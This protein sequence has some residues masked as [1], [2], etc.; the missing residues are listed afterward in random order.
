MA[1][2]NNS[3]L[4]E[5]SGKIGDK[6]FRQMY[7]KT[8]VSERPQNYKAAKTP[9]ARKARSSFGMAVKLAKKL[10]ADPELNEIWTA[11]KIDGVNSNQRILKHNLK[12]FDGGSLTP[13]NIITPEG[14]F[15][16]VESSSFQ[17]QIIHLSLN[18]PAEN[19]LT[20]PAE[21]FLLYYFEKENKSIV[22]NR[23]VITES[24]AGGIYEIDINPDK[25]LL[26]LLQKDP[27][28][29]LFIA[30]AAQTAGKKKPYWTSTA[31]MALSMD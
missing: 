18:C 13:R 28:P 30:M 9:S 26:R 19:N 22:L 31:A 1:I 20:F 27:E 15:L 8:V 21:L 24:S 29:L 7:G 3:V 23:T 11:A 6:V 4:G 25:Y 5:V 17:N 12:L 10:I 14:L 2:L 16:K